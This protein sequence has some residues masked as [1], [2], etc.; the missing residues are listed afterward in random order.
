MEVKEERTVVVTYNV[1][2]NESE[3]LWV[4]FGW[5]TVFTISLHTHTHIHICSFIQFSISPLETSSMETRKNFYLGPLGF[6][7]SFLAAPAAHGSSW[8]RD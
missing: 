2:R 5:A 4:S 1:A 6:F 7:F 3:K 8:A